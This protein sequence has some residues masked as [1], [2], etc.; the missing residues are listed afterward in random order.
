MV[1]SGTHEPVSVAL[2]SS[3]NM[4][5]RGYSGGVIECDEEI[6]AIVE[7]DVIA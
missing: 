1:D 7:I 2:S 5:G 6:E 4:H 3:G